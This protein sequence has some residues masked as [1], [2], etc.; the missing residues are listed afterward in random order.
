MSADSARISRKSDFTRTLSKGVRVSAR[1]LT[2]HVAPLGADWPDESALRPDVATNG[3][4][5]LGLIISKKVG[6]AVI[7]HR[8]ARRLRHAFA[9]AATTG[10]PPET[11]VVLR[12]HPGIV[13]RTSTDLADVL[14]TAFGHRKVVAACARI[15]AEAAHR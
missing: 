10:L 7:R 5:W 4:P 14:R 6:N 12:A 9:E 13:D 15:D 1:D 8:T 11:F 2:V 3:G